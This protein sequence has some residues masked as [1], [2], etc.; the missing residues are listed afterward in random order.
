MFEV[1]SRID[2]VSILRIRFGSLSHAHQCRN[3]AI[4]LNHEAKWSKRLPLIPPEM[5]ESLSDDKLM[6]GAMMWCQL[7]AGPD[8][9]VGVGCVA[10]SQCQA[11]GRLSKNE[12][13]GSSGFASFGIK[14]KTS[15]QLGNFKRH[16]AKDWHIRSVHTY[17]GID[18]S[19]T[20]IVLPSRCP[21]ETDFGK[22]WDSICKGNSP[23]QKLKGIGGR[24]K[25]KK[26]IC[27]LAEAM[28]D[29]DRDVVGR[30]VSCSMM[31]DD[32]DGRMHIR[33]C[34][35]DSM[36]RKRLLFLGQASTVQTGSNAKNKTKN[37]QGVFEDFSTPGKLIAAETAKLD[38]V[39]HEHIRSTLHQMSFD[40]ASNEVL[41]GRMLRDGVNLDEVSGFAPNL[42]TT[43][44]DRTHASRR[45]LSRTVAADEYLNKVMSSWVSGDSGGQSVASAIDSSA[46]IKSKFS[47]FVA[48]DAAH[49]GAKVKNL[50]FANHRYESQAKPLGRM[51]HTIYAVIEKANWVVVNRPNTGAQ[52]A[53]RRFLNHLTNEQYLTAAML[54]DAAAE[55]INLIRFTEPE[56][57]DVADVLGQVEAF[58]RN[59]KF[60]FGHERGCKKAQCFTS[61]ALK[62]LGQ[63]RPFKK[64]T[65]VE[66]FGTRDGITDA[67]FEKC[68]TRMRP[69]F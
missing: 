12:S 65:K 55:D 50:G 7:G 59:I 56:D 15:M 46:E 6:L 67:M 14:N 2:P 60:L 47:E 29:L 53:M 18:T 37:T 40:S 51:V 23:S 5:S 36:F 22:V 64:G 21:K 58:R 63:V 19:T 49:M 57:V 13:R 4:E 27:C 28:Y 45:V 39:L 16:Q 42:K 44:R 48:Q 24:G 43:N 1:D 52:A 61:F 54:A 26:N 38:T 9:T 35:V 31:R 25:Q 33:L 11:N 68:I 30:Q 10:C 8:G 32:S 62:V 34:S 17:L 3:F 69:Q 66:S 20:G 41:G